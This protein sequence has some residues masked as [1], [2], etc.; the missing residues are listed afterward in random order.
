MLKRS[1]ICG[2]AVVRFLVELIQSGPLESEKCVSGS[3]PERP[4]SPEWKVSQLVEFSILFLL[5]LMLKTLIRSSSSMKT[6]VM[7]EITLIQSDTR[8]ESGVDGAEATCDSLE[9]SGA[10]LSKEKGK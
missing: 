5:V 7:T 9:L 10:V 4:C 8:T 3:V 1:N 2:K 6:S